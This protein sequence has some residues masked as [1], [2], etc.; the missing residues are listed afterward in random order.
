MTPLELEFV[1]LYNNSTGDKQETAD[2]VIK[3]IYTLALHQG[4]ISFNLHYFPRK[5]T[6]SRS[7]LKW[8][9]ILASLSQ[10]FMNPKPSFN[11]TTTP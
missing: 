1:Q 4:R 2:L 5:L 6:E 10:H 8:K 9:N 3:I 7:S 11:D